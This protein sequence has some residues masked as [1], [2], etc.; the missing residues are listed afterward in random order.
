MARFDFKNAPPK[1]FDGLALVIPKIDERDD[2]KLT[3]G[4]EK[5]HECR[6]FSRPTNRLRH[7]LSS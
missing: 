4:A 3:A 5:G 7:R 1:L 2:I 6:N